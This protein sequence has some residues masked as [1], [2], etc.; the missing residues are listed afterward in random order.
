[1]NDAMYLMY[2]DETGDPGLLNSPTRYFVLTGLVFHELRWHEYLERLISFRHRMRALYGLKLREEIHAAA[3]LTTPKGLVRIKKYDRLAIVRALID[4]LA[5][6]PDLNII[7][8]V[9]DKQD[10]PANY[11]VF[12]MSWSA[13]GPS[14]LILAGWVL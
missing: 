11:D 13:G 9:V 12:G 3:M 2:A 4:E 1:V 5:Q 8:V 6:M 10:K 7:N 14:G